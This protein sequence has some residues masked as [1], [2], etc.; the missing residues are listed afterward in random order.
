M[1]P[2]EFELTTS[3]GE[4]PQIYT[5]D[6][7]VTGTGVHVCVLLFLLFVGPAGT[8]P[9]ALQP[10]RPFCTLTPVLV[11]PFISRGA[12]CQTA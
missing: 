8:P 1:P 7:A 5:L 10:S 11:P 3:K 12:P 9:I 6:R 4:R 2:A